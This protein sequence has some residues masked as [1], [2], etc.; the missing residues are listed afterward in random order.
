MA[1]CLPDTEKEEMVRARVS[2]EEG[3]LCVLRGTV[4]GRMCLHPGV[5]LWLLRGSKDCGPEPAFK[6]SV[7][8]LKSIEENFSRPVQGGQT[9]ECFWS[10]CLHSEREPRVPTQTEKSVFVNM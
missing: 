1:S 10:G 2:T 3:L 9:T 7:S 4:R 5:G 8:W 6:R